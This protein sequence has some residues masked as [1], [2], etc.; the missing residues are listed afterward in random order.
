[1]FTHTGIEA[2]RRRGA[3]KQSRFRAGS[4]G[5]VKGLY[6][7]LIADLEATA[8]AKQSWG[9]NADREEHEAARLRTRLRTLT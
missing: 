6:R 3:S 5:S 1:M 9:E 4:G 2:R 8:D 7:R